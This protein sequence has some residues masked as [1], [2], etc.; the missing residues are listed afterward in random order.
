VLVHHALE[1][2][3]PAHVIYPAIDAV[4]AG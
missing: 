2:I 4:P 1:A 3:M